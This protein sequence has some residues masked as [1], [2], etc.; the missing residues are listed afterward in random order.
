[1]EVE[2]PKTSKRR[3]LLLLNCIVLSIGQ[4]AGPLL[5]RLYFLHGGNR[6]WFCTWLQ[7]VGWPII[8]LPLTIAFLQ[9]RKT[10]LTSKFFL[11]KLRLVVAFAVLG[12]ITGLDNYL[13]TYGVAR[14][15]VSTSSLIIAS[16]LAFTAGFSFLLVKQNFT[17][18]SI[19]AV[20]LLTIGRGFWLCIQAKTSRR[21]NRL[22]SMLWDF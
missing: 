18:H 20:F 14:L 9:R 17:S 8:L 15:P 5:M 4:S 16:Q 3:A 7:T 2:Q 13:Y 19:N 22:K 10:D 6:V 11:M 21:V 1:M 12:V